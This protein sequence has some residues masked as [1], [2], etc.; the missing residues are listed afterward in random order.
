MLSI[1]EIWPMLGTKSQNIFASAA[2]KFIDAKLP[3]HSSNANIASKPSVALGPL[4]GQTL[5]TL[6]VSLVFITLLIS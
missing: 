6:F 4:Q 5:I 3:K 2:P 1:F